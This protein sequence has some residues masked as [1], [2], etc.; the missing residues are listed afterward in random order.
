[1]CP[2]RRPRQQCWRGLCTP[3]G[4]SRR[5]GFL[6]GTGTSTGHPLQGGKLCRA[7]GQ[8]VCRKATP[9]TPRS[10]GLL[11]GEGRSRR[12]GE[13]DLKGTTKAQLHHGPGSR[14]RQAAA[15]GSTSSAAEQRRHCR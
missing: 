3:S 14:A 4:T 2:P 9:S 10:A 15:A 1:M 11:A 5:R 7:Q 8:G 12:R 13:A 6:E